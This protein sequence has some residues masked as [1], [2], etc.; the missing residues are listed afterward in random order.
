M[1]E[2]SKK[3][4]QKEYWKK[5]YEKHRQEHIDKQKEYVS[6]LQTNEFG[7]RW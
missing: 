1:D 2:N 4:K 3:R 5:W 6:G 7:F